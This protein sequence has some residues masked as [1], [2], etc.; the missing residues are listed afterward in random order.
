[1]SDHIIFQYGG[2]CGKMALIGRQQKSIHPPPSLK[3]RTANKD[4][5]AGLVKLHHRSSEAGK[6]STSKILQPAIRQKITGSTI[7]ER[8]PVIPYRGTNRAH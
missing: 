4:E 3:N 7:P 2:A 5:L 6:S 1:M 8:A